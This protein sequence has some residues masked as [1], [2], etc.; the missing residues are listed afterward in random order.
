MLELSVFD[1]ILKEDYLGPIRSHINI[2]NPL[3]KRL[4]SNSKDISGR[5]AIIPMEFGFNQGVG[6]RK[7]KAILPS[8]GEGEYKVAEQKLKSYYGSMEMTG[9]TMRQSEK[10]DKGSFGRAIDIETKGLKNSLSL[11]LGHD[12]YMGHELGEC[13]DQTVDIAA[14]GITMEAKT[15][16]E[17][18]YKGM[19]LDFAVRSS[20]AYAETSAK[21]K[22][23]KIASVNKS[24]G[25]IKF[26]TNGDD[27][28]DL[29]VGDILV[30]TNTYGACVQGLNDIIDSAGTLQGIDPVSFPS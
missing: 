26:V 25:L 27:S 22:E 4:D 20:G 18:F 14:T 6:A 29:D 13:I 8:A 23:R 16:M 10:G 30:R 5:K 12:F 1:A 28:L 11:M 24:A 15:N 9:Q 7:E 21:S 19:V 17:Y 3:L 2:A